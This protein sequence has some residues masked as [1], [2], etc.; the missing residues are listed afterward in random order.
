MD[1]NDAPTTLSINIQL[2]FAKFDNHTD[3]LPLALTCK[4]YYAAYGMKR[5]RENLN[6]THLITSYWKVEKSINNVGIRDIRQLRKKTARPSTETWKTEVD[7][8]FFDI[9]YNSGTPVRRNLACHSPEEFE[10]IM[11]PI[12]CPR[13]YSDDPIPCT[14]KWIEVKIPKTTRSE[15]E[16][17]TYT[18]ENNS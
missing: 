5:E 13:L 15:N 11:R 3:Q 16:N 17:S 10:L 4:Q 2:I 9:D 8:Q 7:H 18:E 6:L 1:N 12:I 14:L